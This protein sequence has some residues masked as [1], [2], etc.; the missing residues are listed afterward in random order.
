MKICSSLEIKTS[1]VRILKMYKL[2]NIIPVPLPERSPGIFKDRNMRA[3]WIRQAFVW[4]SPPVYVWACAC[5]CV[6][7]HTCGTEAK[8]VK[9]YPGFEVSPHG[10]IFQL[11]SISS[12]PTLNF[13][14]NTPLPLSSMS[15][16]SQTPEHLTLT[17]LPLYSV[18]PQHRRSVTSTRLIFSPGYKRLMGR[19][20]GIS[21]W[22]CQRLC[23]PPVREL[24]LVIA[25]NCRGSVVLAEV[26]KGRR[27][28][29]ELST[30]VS[31]SVYLPLLR[32]L[33]QLFGL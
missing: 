24:S 18:C 1:A 5:I 28:H 23:A 10:T 29:A 33:H 16:E 15:P 20:G 6:N 31:L 25:W 13:P 3:V 27:H 17:G 8:L 21:V 14:Q 12:S 19:E 11:S 7:M 4:G 22:V 26:L 9:P 30:L 2:L 32:I